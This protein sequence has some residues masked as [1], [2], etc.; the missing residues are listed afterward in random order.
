[1]R[2]KSKIE[3]IKVV[4]YKKQKEI[5][6][7][8]HRLQNSAIQQKEEFKHYNN[9]NNE[10]SILTS[11][12]SVSGKH[13]TILPFFLFFRGGNVEELMTIVSTTKESRKISTSHSNRFI[14]SVESLPLLVLVKLVVIDAAAAVTTLS[15]GSDM[16]CL[17]SILFFLVISI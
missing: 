5:S 4:V 2:I 3:I 8:Y 14:S 7:F 11:L 13:Q 9:N 12:A 16:L 1:M 10:T 15:L 17:S 6:I